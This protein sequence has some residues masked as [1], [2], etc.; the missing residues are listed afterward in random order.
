MGVFDT[1]R[2]TA[3]QT[4]NDD[5]WCVIR[6]LN[7]FTAFRTR[8]ATICVC[9]CMCVCKPRHHWIGLCQWVKGYLQIL[10]CTAV[11]HSL[12]DVLRFYGTPCK[13]VGQ[14]VFLLFFLLPTP[15]TNKHSRQQEHLP[16]CSF[17]RLGRFLRDQ[18]E[19]M[20]STEASTPSGPKLLNQLLLLLTS[21]PLLWKSRCSPI[22]TLTHTHVLLWTFLLRST[23][24][25]FSFE[26]HCSSERFIVSFLQ[27][28][29]FHTPW[30]KFIY[31]LNKVEI[32]ASC[33]IF[34][35]P[36]LL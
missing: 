22:G 9:L 28:W 7:E 8:A 23:C 13:N 30:I 25:I 35:P 15:Q 4:L 21:N 1:L 20:V 3:S 12:K 36:S 34:F 24:Q 26:Y 17:P 14:D 31:I 6:E 32:K 27:Y 2:S 16:D 5:S 18:N 10:K 29:L 19:V 11:M 33:P